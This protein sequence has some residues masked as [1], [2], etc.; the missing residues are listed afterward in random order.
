MTKKKI[1]NKDTDKGST[2]AI[3]A[4]VFGVVQGVGFRPFVYRIA[5][6]LGYAGWVKNIGFGVEIHLESKTR[7]DFRDFWDAFDEHKPPLAHIENIKINQANFIN[8][9]DFLIKKSKAG[10]SFVFI[11]PD[12]SVCKD[13]HQEMMDPADRR[14]HYPFINCTDCGPRYTIVR[15]LPYDR[16]TT[17]MERFAMCADC[18]CEYENPIDRRYHAQP[19]ACPVCGPEI[20]LINAK[21][22]TPI[23]GG[24]KR[25]ASLIER[26][27][28]LAVKGLGGFHL[29]CDPCAP[30]AV[31]R[32]RQI[33]ER[34]TKPLALMARI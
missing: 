32:L 29:V 3:D 24:V 25:A 4:V 26:G 18:R 23:K 31:I 21:R 27:K 17:T 5:K 34:K 14:F 10:E 28:I 12:I 30:E 1:Q 16:K 20:S 6:D 19:I 15:A 13:C 9:K 8:C 33:K 2:Q 11:S 22:R 7:R